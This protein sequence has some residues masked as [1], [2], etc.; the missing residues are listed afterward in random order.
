MRTHVIAILVLLVALPAG[1]LAQGTGGTTQTAATTP[2]QAVMNLRDAMIAGDEE[3][4]VA[5]FQAGEEEQQAMLVGIF[6]LAQAGKTLQDAVLENFGEEGLEEFGQEMGEDLYGEIADVTADDLV[7]EE[8]GDT[9]TVRKVDEEEDDAMA[10]VRE[11]GVW[12]ISFEDELPSGEEA[13]QALVFI[14]AMAEVMNETAQAADDEGM[15]VEQLQQEM[16]AKM[17][18][19]MMMLMAAQEEMEDDEGW[20]DEDEVEVDDEDEGEAGTPLN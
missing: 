13:V 10:L 1:A 7:I 17:M 6:D 9:A 5:C 12:L 8:D 11:G 19:V 4:F 15:T 14:E 16:N 3:A 20:E 18:G 2:L